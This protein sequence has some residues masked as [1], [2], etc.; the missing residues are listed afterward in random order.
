MNLSYI[1]L[2]SSS[3]SDHARQ[4][5]KPNSEI[6]S[7]FLNNTDGST[8]LDLYQSNYIQRDYYKI[9]S[10]VHELDSTTL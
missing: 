7:Y 2:I 5:K 6:I 8:T 3:F 9:N 4:V 1:D 10:K